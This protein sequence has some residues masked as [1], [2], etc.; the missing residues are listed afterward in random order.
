M[1]FSEGLSDYVRAVAAL[2]GLTLEE[3]WVPSV[4]VHLKRLLDASQIVE[5]S[6][7]KSQDLAPRFEP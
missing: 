7:L 5:R 1:S 4:T 3:A 2:R 6:E